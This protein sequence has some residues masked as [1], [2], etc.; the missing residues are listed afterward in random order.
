MATITINK[1]KADAA[2]QCKTEADALAM[3]L[4]VEMH[5][6]YLM[7]RDVKGVDS[8]TSNARWQKRVT[9]KAPAL[10]IAGAGVRNDTPTSTVG[11]FHAL[12]RRLGQPF[13]GTAAQKSAAED[14][15]VEYLRK[16]PGQFKEAGKLMGKA[17][18]TPKP[19][20]TVGEVVNTLAGM[21]PATWTAADIRRLEKLV[22]IARATTRTKGAA[23]PR[24]KAA[25]V[26]AA[27]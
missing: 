16:N 4:L 5:I 20:V 19:V 17:A 2:A 18:A 8:F 24:A 3:R 27:A 23:K 10:R 1:V 22:A 7:V 15:V 14:K 12:V 13:A 6:A 21:P 26:L 9:D 25:P 11:D